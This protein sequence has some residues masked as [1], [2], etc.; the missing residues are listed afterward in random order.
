MRYA[1]LA[2]LLCG[3]VASAAPPQRPKADKSETK[4]AMPVLQPASAGPC[5]CPESPC[6]CGDECDCPDCLK[7]GRR[8]QLLYFTTPDCTYC[9]P[10]AKRTFPALVRA[11]WIVGQRGHIRVEQGPS[12]LADRFGVTSYPTWILLRD[13]QEVRRA[14][15]FLDPFDVGELFKG[16]RE[17]PR[18]REP[19]PSWEGLPPAA[20]GSGPR[21]EYH[22]P[23]NLA[24][25]LQAQHG[26]SAAGL[27]YEQQ[28]QLHSDIHNGVRARAVPLYRFP[29]YCPPGAT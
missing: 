3:C 6:V 11:G 27:S 21:W 7:H 2:L 18:G 23:G 10:V 9:E 22:G 26:V 14:T 16:F 19:L 13:G 25:H 17:T 4:T 8:D 28:V 24:S 5:L 1:I 15:G 12:A 29:A 20:R